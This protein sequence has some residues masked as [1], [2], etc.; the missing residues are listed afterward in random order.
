MRHY[1][2]SKHSRSQPKDRT[3]WLSY[4]EALIEKQ[5]DNAKVLEQTKSKAWKKLDVLETQITPTEQVNEPKLVVQK[6]SNIVRRKEWLMKKAEEDKKQSLK[7]I[8]PSE[9]K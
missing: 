7:A 5:F 8:S 6:K 3:I 9:G 4:I 2:Y 1:R